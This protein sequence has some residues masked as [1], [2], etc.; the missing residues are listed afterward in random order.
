MSKK[1]LE[2]LKIPALVLLVFGLSS[3]TIWDFVDSGLYN[4]AGGNVA[5]KGYFEDTEYEDEIGVN[6]YALDLTT[7]ATAGVSDFPA[8]GDGYYTLDTSKTLKYSEINGSGGTVNIPSVSDEKTH[9]LVIPVE[10]TGYEF[11]KTYPHYRQD[12]VNALNGDGFSDTGYWESVASYYKKSSY[13]NLDLKFDIAPIFKSGYTAKGLYSADDGAASGP[14]SIL[15]NAVECYRVKYGKE[16][17]RKYDY[18]GDGWLDG[19]IMIYSCPDFQSSSQIARIDSNGGLYWAFCYWA[20]E[21]FPTAAEKI[22]PVANLFFW[23]SASF[24]Y[25]QTVVSPRSDG[26]TFIHEFG[27]MLGL[28]DYYAVMTSNGT[29]ESYNPAGGWIMEDHNILDHDIWS[30]TALGWTKPYVV[31]GNCTIEINPATVSG[32]CIIIPSGHFNGTAFS[33]FLIMELYTPTDLNYLDSHTAYDGRHFGYSTFGVRLWHVDARIARTNRRT[34]DRQGNYVWSYY[35]GNKIN[36]NDGYAY[37]VAASNS[38]KSVALAENYSLLSL[39]DASGT[40]DFERGGL[41]ENKCLF[42]SGD[43]FS[44]SQSKYQRYFPNGDCFNDGSTSNVT[45]S[46]DSVT[47]TQATISFTF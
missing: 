30:K 29:Y 8:S 41:G 21:R 18:D 5:G 1:L 15:N 35:D 45:V 42:R 3:C 46:F 33:E 43:T 12:L 19:V 22:D 10:I 40:I 4:S 17:V 39:I 9:V 38:N 2:K 25:T 26:H 28:D 37:R 27:H 6:H 31:N 47:N 32:D 36:S 16:A 11:S 44:F 34:T 23:A 24:L 7:H 13:G 14:I 20:A